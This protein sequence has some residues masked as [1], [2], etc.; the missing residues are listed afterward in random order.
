MHHWHLSGKLFSLLVV[1]FKHAER[2]RVSE[3]ERERERKRK[4]ERESERD[5][6]RVRARDVWLTRHDHK[7]KIRIDSYKK[8]SIPKH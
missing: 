6:E 3:R 5:S 2:V 1:V 7:T 8:T 4:R